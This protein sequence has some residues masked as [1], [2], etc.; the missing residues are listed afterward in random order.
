MQR[1]KRSNRLDRIIS[2]QATC[3][4]GHSKS[5][6]VL[7]QLQEATQPRKMLQN[8]NLTCVIAL[9]G[10]SILSAA[11]AF[12]TQCT[13]SQYYRCNIKRNHPKCEVLKVGSLT[14]HMRKPMRK[15]SVH[16]EVLRLA[17]Q[18]G[19]ND[20][21]SQSTYDN[22]SFTQTSTTDSTFTPSFF[23]MRPA[24]FV[25]LGFAG[26]MLTEAF[27]SQGRNFFS[28]QIEKFKTILHL[29]SVFNAKLRD[30]KHVR[31]N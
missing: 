20:D 4:R 30:E 26:N 8:W 31:N 25:D 28:Y 1:L 5:I 24:Q 14:N 18:N 11:T 10:L 27:F 15:I 17:L 9:Y 19:P 6:N 12:M 7:H 29:E 2:N 22:P 21:I 16:G 13:R 23:F 3:T